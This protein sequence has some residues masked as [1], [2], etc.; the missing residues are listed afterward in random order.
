MPSKAHQHTKM[1]GLLPSAI[2]DG[3]EWDPKMKRNAREVEG[4]TPKTEANDGPKETKPKPNPASK[5]IS[6]NREEIAKVMMA[7]SQAARQATLGLPFQARNEVGKKVP[8]PSKSQTTNN[9]QPVYDGAT[10]GRPALSDE[11]IAAILR[12][13]KP[14]CN[15]AQTWIHAHEFTKAIQERMKAKME[16]RED[17][18]KKIHR[19][20]HAQLMVNNPGANPTNLQAVRGDQVDD[21]KLTPIERVQRAHDRLQKALAEILDV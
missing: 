10:N 21:D 16:E 18:R 4:D 7:Q 12:Y 2:E 3:K 13:T 5:R 8:G 9:K 19:K 20:L 14:E 11:A 17:L 6:I 1:R 15:K